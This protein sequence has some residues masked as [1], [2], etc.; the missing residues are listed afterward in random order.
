[1]ALVNCKE[2]GREVSDQAKACVGCGAPIHDSKAEP[3]E[4]GFIMKAFLFFS[5]FILT[6]MRISFALMLVSCA[7]LAAYV[8]NSEAWIWEDFV[9]IAVGALLMYLLVWLPTTV[10]M[11]I[12]RRV[13]SKGKKLAFILTSIALPF[14]S[15]VTLFYIDSR[16]LSVTEYLI[17]KSSATPHCSGREA[18]QLLGEMVDDRAGFISVTNIKET[19]FNRQTKTRMCKGVLSTSKY[20]ARN[21]QYLI[22]LDED[23]GVFYI[24]MMP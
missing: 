18:V 4:Y 1:M 14:V 23:K 8:Y 6:I 10:M 2:C 9:A 13:K 24:K 22:S 21:I 19:G 15:G 20:G 11:N 3:A 16:T 17:N 7:A 5:R 12:D